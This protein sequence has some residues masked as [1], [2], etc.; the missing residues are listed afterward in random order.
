[1][2]L[3]SAMYTLPYSVLFI[4]FDLLSDRV[5]KFSDLILMFKSVVRAFALLTQQPLPDVHLV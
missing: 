3:Q 1:M 2:Y 4:V 5:L